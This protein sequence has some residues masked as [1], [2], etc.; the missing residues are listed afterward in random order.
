MRGFKLKSAFKIEKHGYGIVFP[1]GAGDMIRCLAEN[2]VSAFDFADINSFDGKR[3]V[4]TIYNLRRSP[5]GSID[6]E[7]HYDEL[8]LL[9]CAF[10]YSHSLNSPINVSGGFYRHY[11]EPDFDLGSRYK[12]GFDGVD[13]GK[14][15]RSGTL[16]F[17][18]EGKIWQFTGMMVRSFSISAN[19]RG[20]RFSFSL[21]GKQLDL[22]SHENPDSLDWTLPDEDAPLMLF[23]DIA[24]YLKP[25][26][27][28]S[29][30][31]ENNSMVFYEEK[32]KDVVISVP[33]GDYTGGELARELEW[34]LNDS[35]LNG[36]YKV[37]YDEEQRRFI[38]ISDT[39]FTIYGSDSPSTMKYKI[40]YDLTFLELSQRKVSI[41]DAQPTPFATFS[42]SDLVP[43]DD[44][45]LTIGNKLIFQTDSTSMNSC[46]E[47]YGGLN[48]VSGTLRLPRYQIN[49]RL[50]GIDFGATYE[51]K[52]CFSNG[53]YSFDIFLPAVKFQRGEASVG[54]THQVPEVLAFKAQEP[55]FTDMINFMPGEYFWR[56]LPE[57]P[58]K[59]CY[60]CG[61]HDGKLYAT[62]LISGLGTFVYYLE[63]SEWILVGAAI[64][65][66]PRSLASFKGDIFLGAGSG[67]IYRWTGSTWSPV[68]D[69]GNDIKDMV[70]FNDA[71]FALAEDGSVDYTT[72]GT[73]WNSSRTGSATM[74]WRLISY[75]G[76]LFA[77]VNEDTAK[78]L[79]FDGTTWSHSVSFGVE[80]SSGEYVSLAIHRG[81]LYATLKNWV[82]E[83]N[84][85]SWKSLPN[86]GGEN[87]HIASFAGNLLMFRSATDSDPYVYDV[88][89]GTETNIY[90]GFN[91]TMGLGYPIIF[92]GKL[93]IV[94][95]GKVLYVPPVPR[96]FLSETNKISTNPLEEENLPFDVQA[97][98]WNKELDMINSSQLF[99]VTSASDPGD[100]KVEIIS[101]DL[102]GLDPY[103]FRA[104]QWYYAERS[105]KEWVI[106]SRK[107]ISFD[108]TTG[109]IKL[110]NV[111][112]QRNSNSNVPSPGTKF[113]LNGSM[114]GWIHYS[115]DIAQTPLISTGTSPGT[116]MVVSP[117]VFRDDE[118]N[119]TGEK[120]VMVYGGIDTKPELKWTYATADYPLGPFTK[121]GEI[122]IDSTML[123][124]GWT[125]KGS[126]AGC[127]IKYE[128]EWRFYT[129]A[130]DG[131]TDFRIFL[132]TA[133]SLRGPYT[134]YDS[135]TGD[136]E[137]FSNGNGIYDANSIVQPEIIYWNG[138]F[139]M[140]YAC[141]GS[142]GK[143]HFAIATSSDGLSFSPHGSNPI[144][145]SP[146]N[147]GWGAN[148][149]YGITSINNWIVY[150]GNLYA[151]V[152][153]YDEW[154][155]GGRS[156]A[157]LI[158]N[159]DFSQFSEHPLNPVLKARPWKTDDSSAYG[160]GHWGE[161]FL[162]RHKGVWYFYFTS[163]LSA[164]SY[165]IYVMYREWD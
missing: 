161:G 11:F 130:Y 80:A 24:V 141:D 158:P 13:S 111:D 22:N 153:G 149:Q 70:I 16:L 21:D 45:N 77:A 112:W 96:I 94:A 92:Q 120:V 19:L 110:D 155:A 72:D 56:E 88:S 40:G 67:H 44:F 115:F 132:F 101:N 29:I 71:L 148:T 125:I 59:N 146:I 104:G 75:N 113:R 27:K 41:R 138:Q 69:M 60:L 156:G 4:T 33:A 108:N 20:V 140:G 10:G 123:P 42:S 99:T 134:F 14:L 136:G 55:S 128:N 131:S 87:R 157:I 48:N 61:V 15:R 38:F 53:N 34:R 83:Y 30:T 145:S 162:Y 50:K 150:K 147:S 31:D 114:Q 86:S 84:G 47:P 8:S 163:E 18:K 122:L 91:K 58:G 46:S 32:I 100:G 143:R 151:L 5:G 126:G 68:H 12:D 133:S 63:G 93:I 105:G 119:T 152:D 78:I 65:N 49:D 103:I 39:P 118:N 135:G 51:M 139:V 144:L 2:V 117:M 54:G 106:N 85:V 7:P 98:V 160:K 107:I 82:L 35:E 116:L 74:A 73:T 89:D 79:E 66:T 76:K 17:D 109:K 164:D 165:Q 95:D 36:T 81:L 121:S 62:E 154:T 37:E 28:F 52:I 137:V 159:S 127:L 97:F 23:S 3:A 26:D 129:V 6:I 25:R 57:L 90:S 9:A 1:A 102:I 64:A 142:D 124:S 43:V